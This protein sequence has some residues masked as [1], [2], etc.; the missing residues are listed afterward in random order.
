MEPVSVIELVLSVGGFTLTIW[1]LYKTKAAAEAARDS[2][3]EAVQ[4]VRQMHAVSTMQDIAGRS[5]SLLNLI[6][7]KNIA[8]AA[9]AAFELRDAVSKYQ[10]PSDTISPIEATVWAELTQEV[11]SLHDR[12][13]TIA[14]LNRWTKEERE[15]F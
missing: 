4:G 14:V 15:T 8:A 9:A 6:K 7:T 13:E 12:L 2:A 3:N 5:R 1:Q 11:D 10:T